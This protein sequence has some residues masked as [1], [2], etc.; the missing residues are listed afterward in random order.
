M[1][2][3]KEGTMPGIAIGIRGPEVEVA[4]HVAAGHTLAQ[5]LALVTVQGAGQGIVHD[6]ETAAAPEIGQGPILVLEIAAA[7]E[8]DP[9]LGHSQ[10]IESVL[11]HGMKKETAVDLVHQYRMAA[12][13]RR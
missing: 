11:D 5:D 1:S 2:V 8:V 7:P 4:L 13:K 9:V 10:E 6:R 12:Q 3:A